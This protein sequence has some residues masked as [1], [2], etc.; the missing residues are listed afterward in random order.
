MESLP[1]PELKAIIQL[2]L[3]HISE[4]TRHLRISDAVF[5]LKTGP[6]FSSRRRNTRS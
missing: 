3:I 4:P 5:C 1:P 6:P 2:S